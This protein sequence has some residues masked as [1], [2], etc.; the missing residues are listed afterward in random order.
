MS[1]KIREYCPNGHPYTKENI[2]DPPHG[3]HICKTCY[4]N[5]KLRYYHKH[6]TE[7]NKYRRNLKR[8]KSEYE[9]IREFAKTTKYGLK[10][11]TL[12][13]GTIEKIIVLQN[14]LRAMKG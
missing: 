3:T 8:I 9:C 7:L 14:N 10:I 1:Y 12:P 13:N 5:G 11:W 6:Q 2:F 4:H